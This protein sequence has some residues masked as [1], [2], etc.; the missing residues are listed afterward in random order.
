MIYQNIYF[1]KCKHCDNI[2]R[3]Y[4]LV[5]VNRA[6]SKSLYSKEWDEKQEFLLY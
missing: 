2:F 5:E 4:K 1:S 6:K 3:Y